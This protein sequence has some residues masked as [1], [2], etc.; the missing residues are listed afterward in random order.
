MKLT[1]KQWIGS[2]VIGMIAGGVI[3]Y[4]VMGTLIVSKLTF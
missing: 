1:T 3:V 4:F 2:M